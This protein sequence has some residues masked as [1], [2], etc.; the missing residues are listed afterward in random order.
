MKVS[1]YLPITVTTLSMTMM[2]KLSQLR[3]ASAFTTRTSLRRS[4]GLAASYATLPQTEDENATSELSSATAQTDNVA[5]LGKFPHGK[6]ISNKKEI[7]A[8]IDRALGVSKPPDIEVILTDHMTNLNNSLGKFLHL[9][10]MRFGHIAIRYTTSD[11]KQ[12]VMNIMGD[13]TDPDSTLINFFEPSEYFYGTDPKVAQQ[14]GVY[15]R[16]FV[17]VRIENAAP[18]A[19]DALHAY[20][21][22]VSKASEIGSDAA[23][24]AVKKGTK[25]STPTHKIAGAPGS[26]R[27]GAARFQLVEVQFSRLARVLPS[28]VDKF[29]YGIA[30]WIREKDDQRR[31]GVVSTFKAMSNSMSEFVAQQD[32]RFTNGALQRAQED[33]EENMKDIRGSI[34]QSGNCAQWTSGGLDFSGQIR[35]ARLFPK[36]ILVDLLEDEYLT[37]GRPDNVN[38]VYYS[39]VEHA[40]VIYEGYK[41]IK[42]AMVHPLKTVRNFYYDDMKEFAN[43]IVEVPPGTD[44]AVVR[45]QKPSKV[46][47]PWLQYFTLGTIYIPAAVMI[48][49]VDH[50]GP[51]GPMAASAWLLANW[52]LY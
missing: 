12:H 1:S 51:V 52:W 27:R 10:I 19:T 41:C 36:A 42:S 35:R 29:F 4:R 23:T 15:S 17:G 26:S 37:N 33:M 40:P 9:N 44:K 45:A 6:T 50:V 5:V 31:E 47:Q 43:A 38:V 16:P 39:E 49:L 48:G 34:Y 7:F 22:A 20:Y 24:S 13:F 8:D 28:P 14:G 30:D 18:G 11:G 2:I 46:P 25:S 21:K 32:E 3:V